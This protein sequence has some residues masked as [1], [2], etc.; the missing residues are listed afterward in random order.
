MAPVAAQVALSLLWLVLALALLPEREVPGVGRHRL[1][2][3][4][5]RGYGGPGQFSILFGEEDGERY[6]L[7][8]PGAAGTQA[9]PL[10]L[11]L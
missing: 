11:L 6:P 5:R 10:L 4:W 8:V 3:P 9:T 1:T 2:L 7:L